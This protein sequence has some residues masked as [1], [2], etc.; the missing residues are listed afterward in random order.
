ME[1]Y[2]IAELARILKIPESTVRY[3]RDRHQD[4]MPHT[5]TARGGGGG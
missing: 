3:Y 2:T 5:G 4:Y 1:L